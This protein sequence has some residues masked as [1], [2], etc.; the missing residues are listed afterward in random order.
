MKQEN[1]RNK[2]K[3]NH[4]IT[5]LLGIFF[6]VL[7][8]LI[9]KT[10]QNWIDVGTTGMTIFGVFKLI[11][12]MA[13]FIFYS[14]WNFKSASQET[15]GTFLKYLVLMMIPFLVMTIITIILTYTA[16]NSS[17]GS[18]W[19]AVTFFIAP[20]VFCFI[21]F[22]IIYQVMSS[23]PVAVFFIICLLFMAVFQIIGFLLGNGSRKFAKERE[24]IRAE[25]DRKM[26]KRQDEMARRA[27]ENRQR[28]E[29]RRRSTERRRTVVDENDPLKDIESTAVVE[30]EAFSMITDDM[31]R[32][33]IRQNKIK[34]TEQKVAERM[35]KNVLNQRSERNTVK[36]AENTAQQD[37]Q[38]NPQVDH[39]NQAK[40]EQLKATQDL[41]KE[42]ALIRER[43]AKEDNNKQ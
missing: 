7:L 15:F 32:E 10:I 6:Y 16:S 30:T 38:K 17:F 3:V 36:T 35:Q 1:Y 9:L 26:M 18:N 8:V 24:L 33:A 34:T 13:F 27:I 40:K 25:Q 22:G 39:I 2:M 41:Q 42:L 37:I 4:T 43:L 29:E 5:A 28:N 23:L 14:W 21:P 19:N 12:V 11:I 20:T 31:I